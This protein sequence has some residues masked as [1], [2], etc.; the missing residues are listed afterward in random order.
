MKKKI[1]S[2]DESLMKGSF[3]PIEA[4]ETSDG[5]VFMKQQCALDHQKQLDYKETM[6]NRSW[7]K[8]LLNL[9]P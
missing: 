7:F 8:K 5:E 9:K 2:I 6:K 1:N 3:I 4:Y